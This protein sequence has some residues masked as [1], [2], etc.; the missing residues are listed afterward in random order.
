M[1]LHDPDAPRR[2]RA[3][4]K[5]PRRT[6]PT[7]AERAP[8]RSG[9]PSSRRSPPP[10]RGGGR[11]LG[12][13]TVFQIK[14]TKPGVGRDEVRLQGDCRLIARDRLLLLEGAF[15]SV[16]E[17]AM[18]NFVAG[19][20]AE[21]GGECYRRLLGRPAAIRAR[22]RP[23]WAGATPGSS[24]TA[25]SSRGNRLRRASLADQH[26]LPGRSAGLRAPAPL[27]F[28]RTAA[29]PDLSKAPL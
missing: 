1:R 15:V 8:R 22:P 16:A 10:R 24:L 4:R 9:P 12:A 11:R 6:R 5:E 17:I 3:S 19:I 23:W 27:L 14:F 21:S 7:P 29:R 28:R 20:E 26:P 13:P 18:R 2:R 25:R